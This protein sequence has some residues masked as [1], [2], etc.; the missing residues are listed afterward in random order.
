[1]TEG[2][3]LGVGAAIGVLAVYIGFG[4]VALAIDRRAMLVSALVY[5][6]FALT[7]LFREFGA[8][9]LNLR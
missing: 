7:F 2:D 9:E 4:L 3:N 1:M 5:V 6:L 8:V